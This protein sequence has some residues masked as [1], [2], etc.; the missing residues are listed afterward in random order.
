[1][2]SSFLRMNLFRTQACSQV[3]LRGGAIQRPDGPNGTERASLWG[4]GRGALV[5][6]PFERV[7]VSQLGGSGGMLP[8]K[9]LN[10]SPL[11]M[12]RNAF[13]TNM[14]WWNL[15][16]FSNKKCRHKK[17]F[18]TKRMIQQLFSEPS[19]LFDNGSLPPCW[20]KQLMR[21][22]N[23]NIVLFLV[24]H[25]RAGILIRKLN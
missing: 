3:F 15:Y 11:E 1:M 22:A 19:T 8:L 25:C 17:L 14:V 18:S 10:L 21:L 20:S 16:T 7:S 23:K 9:F 4:R 24:L 13:K 12:A 5:V 6:A 2:W